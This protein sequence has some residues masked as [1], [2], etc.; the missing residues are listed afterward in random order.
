MPSG[1]DVELAK[2]LLA[3]AVLSQDRVKDALTVQAA[4]LAQG[5]TVS[6]ERVLVGKG[7]LPREALETLQSRDP[8]AEQPFPGYRLERALGEGGSSV[9]Y[10]G[11]YLAN[12]A[13]VA[14][15]VFDAVQSL[16][17]DL[18]ARFYEEARLLI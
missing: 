16:R 11:K 9:V 6:L 5:K 3:A 14:V 13:T 15:K 2:K 12:G 17:P 7:M 1:R 8:V 4:L 10:A 18:L